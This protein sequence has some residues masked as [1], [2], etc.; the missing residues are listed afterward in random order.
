MAGPAGDVAVRVLGSLELQVD[1]QVVP[2]TSP[3]LRM[4]LSALV[5]DANVVVSTDRLI[6]IL[7]GDEPPAAALRSLHTHI[8]RLRTLLEPGCERAEAGALLVT[9]TPGYVLQLEPLQSDASYF[10]KLVHQARA[11]TCDDDPAAAASTLDLALGIWRGPAFAEF[12]FDDFARP[13][14]VRLEELRVAAIEQ[15]VD[16]N[17]ALGRHAELIGDLEVSVAAFPL[18]ERLRAQLMVALYRSGRQVEALRAFQNFRRYL[19]DELGLEPSKA[20]HD[21]EDAIVLQK[22]A[23][24]LDVFPANG[25]AGLVD[26]EHLIRRVAPRPAAAVQVA[27]PALDSDRWPS[28]PSVAPTGNLPRQVT[29]FVGRRH[30]IDIVGALVQEHPLVS[31]TGPGGV[32]KT[33]LA[34]EVAAEVAVKFPDGVWICALAP[35]ADGVWETLAAGLDLRPAPKRGWDDIVCEYLALKRALLVFDNC[36]HLVDEAASVVS[37]LTQ[38]CR[39]VAILATS[40]ECLALSGERIVAVS[41]LEVPEVNAAPEAVAQTEAGR[42]FCDRAHDAH[43]NFV[44]TDRNAAA[45][46]QLCR[47]LDGI[48]LAIELAA[49]RVRS[50]PLEDVVAR[51]DQRFELLTQGSRA[52]PQRHQTLRNTIDWSYDL[53]TDPERSALNRLAVFAGGCDLAA[54]EAVVAS[55]DLKAADTADVI[56]KLVDK[57]LVLLEHHDNGTRF[58]LLETI[59][60]YAQERLETSGET[61]AVRR[62]HLEYFVA[63]AETARPHLRRHD[64]LSWARKLERDIDNFRAALDYA[65]EERLAKHALRLVEPL[66]VPGLRI[67]WAAFDWAKIAHRI[68]DAATHAQ[69]P[70]V[71]AIAAVG[72]VFSGYLEHAATLVTTAAAAQHVR[73]E[74]SPHAHTAD[75]LGQ[76]LAAE[77]TVALYRGDLDH[78]AHQAETYIEIAR[79]EGDPFHLACALTMYGSVLTSDRTRAAVAEEEAVRVARDAHI[80]SALLYALLALSSCLPPDDDRAFALIDEIV[81]VGTALGDRNAVAIA[82]STRGAI[83]ALHQDWQGALRASVAAAAQYLDGG[84]SHALVAAL[85]VAFVALAAIGHSEPAAIMI[86]LVDEHFGRRMGPDDLRALMTDA[87]AA[88]LDALGASRLAELKD[89]GATLSFPDAADY[90]Q[91]QANLALHQT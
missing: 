29:T 28:R 79:G 63:L 14:A 83:A 42:L 36:E 71:V 35:A 7:W 56:S 9:R 84:Q 21:L 70:T 62:R 77:V 8:Y 73:D 11:H 20:L 40:R 17:L 5:I 59:R 13:E 32:G 75:E 69:F 39:G 23:L 51:L 66:A 16:A 78:A 68:P 44:L 48:P 50:L 15:R 46:G 57:S 30:E 3:K 47:R 22:S 49:A 64:Q 33:R 80:T 4:L 86:G 91:A 67:G 26:S 25:N 38:R 89:Q 31:L 74:N 6:Q 82:I 55:S 65:V 81:D 85:Q 58:R 45:T 2:L 43:N 27:Q 52:A 76:L 72:T 37:A 41:P 87:D 19:G 12:A 90:L 24:E 61:A 1:G 53:L 88:L 60:Q 10:E 18:R 54:C 34:L